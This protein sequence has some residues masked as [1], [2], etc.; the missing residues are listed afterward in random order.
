MTQGK[1]TSPEVQQ[2]VL[3]YLEMKKPVKWIS[4]KT[5][6]GV[7][8]IWKIKKRGEI[9]HSNEYKS[10]PGR[11][12]K[13]S[14]YEKR[15]IKSF[16][17]KNERKTLHFTKKELKLEVSK[18]TLSRVFREIEIS[19]R[20]MI[21]KPTLTHEHQKKRV[22]WALSRCSPDFDWSEWIFS[23]EKKFNHGL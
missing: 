5:G 6:L 19:M 20:K 17:Q 15:K 13:V 22:E 18:Q 1:R 10:T 12:P 21:D 16:V 23:D 8:T 14:R 3:T 4:S 11:P 7:R 2:Q 9:Q